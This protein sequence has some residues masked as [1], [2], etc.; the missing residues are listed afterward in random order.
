MNFGK[1]LSGVPFEIEKCDMWI[2]HG[3]LNVALSTID[4]Y[5]SCIHP[6][7]EALMLQGIPLMMMVP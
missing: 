5:S 3:L 6:V 2:P 7:N 1:N 4:R